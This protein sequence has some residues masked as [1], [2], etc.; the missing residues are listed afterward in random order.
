MMR[1]MQTFQAIPDKYKNLYR[2]WYS[3]VLA[4]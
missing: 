4:S 1:T 3:Y 2:I